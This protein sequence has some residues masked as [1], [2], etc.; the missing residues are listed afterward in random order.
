MK[1][2]V[3]VLMM[4]IV[5]AGC[6]QQAET[7]SKSA[8][9]NGFGW[10]TKEDEIKK[11][12]YDLKEYEWAEENRYYEN[13]PEEGSDDPLISYQFLN[14]DDLLDAITLNYTV[15]DGKEQDKFDTIVREIS[16][17]KG[18]A[19][20]DLPYMQDYKTVGWLDDMTATLVYIAPDDNPYF[21]S[22]GVRYMPRYEYDKNKDNYEILTNG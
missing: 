2:I 6:G 4:C 16:N 12:G 5:L 22:V 13:S 17:E 15:D 21:S 7:E 1:R 9:Y 18:S 10:D 8:V 11:L 20:S 14:S 3:A 19:P